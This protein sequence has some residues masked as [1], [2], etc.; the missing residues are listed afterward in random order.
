M[1]VAERIIL[2]K[3]CTMMLASHGWAKTERFF[4]LKHQPEPMKGE[5][6]VS[7]DTQE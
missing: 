5:S 4:D 7:C 1:K 6:E 3:L 2:S